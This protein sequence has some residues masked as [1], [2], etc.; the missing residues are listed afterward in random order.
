MIKSRTSRRFHKI[1]QRE[2]PNSSKTFRI[3]G[4]PKDTEFKSFL[5]FV[6]SFVFMSQQS[7]EA[8]PRTTSAKVCNH[9]G[10]NYWLFEV[11]ILGQQ[12]SLAHPK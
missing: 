6:Y 7:H 8:L 9:Q 10:H 3:C 11:T 4:N 2:I 12:C 1:Y 5:Y